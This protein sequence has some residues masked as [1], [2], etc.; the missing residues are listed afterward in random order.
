MRKTLSELFVILMV[1]VSVVGCAMLAPKP[2][3]TLYERLGGKSAIQAVVNDFIDRVGAD[4]R[5]TN[6][7][8][9]GQA[10]CYP[11][12]HP[13]SACHQSGLCGRGRSV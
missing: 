2:E 1:M 12:S 10:G 3:A 9:E 4:P 7:Q 5:I 8:G 13:Q 11:Y 6:E